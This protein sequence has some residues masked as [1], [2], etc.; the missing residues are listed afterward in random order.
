MLIWVCHQSAAGSGVRIPDVWLDVLLD[1]VSEHGPL[2]AHLRGLTGVLDGGYGRVGELRTQLPCYLV[3]QADQV[4]ERDH[5]V[6]D[7]RGHAVRRGVGP[8]G[9]VPEHAAARFAADRLDRR[10]LRGGVL[11][12]DF[13]E[14]L[15]ARIVL[16][17]GVAV[18]VEAV[19]EQ[20]HVAGVGLGVVVV[21]V[22][23]ALVEAGEAITVGVDDRFQAGILDSGIDVRAGVGIRIAVGVVELDQ[24]GLAVD[25][26]SLTVHAVATGGEGE[27][28]GGERGE[29]GHESSMWPDC[30][31]RVVKTFA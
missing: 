30:A 22:G 8:V 5:V 28:E 2:T 11:A 10:V 31:G 19:V 9:P 1:A 7:L 16:G 21:A 4:V 23:A 17:G 18:V 25:Q 29:L 15:G 13:S 26:L 6:H 27:R 12:A 3:V 24:G 14:A 20:F